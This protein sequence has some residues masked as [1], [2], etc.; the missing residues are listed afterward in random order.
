MCKYG[1][2]KNHIR[3]QVWLAIK[4]HDSPLILNGSW[5]DPALTNLILVLSGLAILGDVVIVTNTIHVTTDTLDMLGVG[6]G[7]SELYS[8][9]A[10]KA[11]SY[12][13]LTL[14]GDHGSNQN[15]LPARINIVWQIN[16][17]SIDLKTR[18]KFFNNSITMHQNN[19]IPS[20]RLT[21]ASWF[22]LIWIW[23]P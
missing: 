16:L 10:I 20:R 19:Q 6:S 3:K 2:S 13:V 18:G 8:V 9:V 1:I 21:K 22:F 7:H 12:A 23:D 14:K 5:D 17:L 4:G 11:S 15:Q